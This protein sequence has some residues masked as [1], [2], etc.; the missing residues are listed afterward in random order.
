MTKDLSI[1]EQK[2]VWARENDGA[3]ATVIQD[4]VPTRLFRLFKCYLTD[5]AA[6]VII[7]PLSSAEKTMAGM[8][9][10]TKRNVVLECH[11]WTSALMPF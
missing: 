1:Y 11:E 3:N 10:S 2:Q 5:F 4:Q 9:G 7:L 8:G 6:A